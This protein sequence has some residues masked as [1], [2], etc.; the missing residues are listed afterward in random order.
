[1]VKRIAIA[2]I[3]FAALLAPVQASTTAVNWH[4]GPAHVVA[5]ANWNTPPQPT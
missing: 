4:E 5:D 1:M 3:L 2:L